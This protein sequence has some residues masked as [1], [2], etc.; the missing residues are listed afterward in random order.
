[1]VAFRVTPP[2]KPR[3]TGE[4]TRL[5]H[6]RGSPK[7]GN[8][9]GNLWFELDDDDD[10][11]D[12]DSRHTVFL[13]EY[14]DEDATKVENYEQDRPYGE[15]EIVIDVERKNEQ[16]IPTPFGELTTCWLSLHVAE[17]LWNVYTYEFNEWVYVRK[18]KR[19]EVVI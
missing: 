14:T 10:E 19:N 18:G 8:T 9:N 15:Y 2:V 6:W 16:T 3:L 11:Y 17:K 12:P 1:M 13:G 5:G 7:Y 4:N